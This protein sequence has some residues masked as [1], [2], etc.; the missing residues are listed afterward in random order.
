MSIEIIDVHRT[1]DRANSMIEYGINT[2]EQR[3]MLLFFLMQ[4]K[5]LLNGFMDDIYE[6]SAAYEE[7]DF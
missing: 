5:Q 1:L 4:A 3:T 6:E 2:P 7:A